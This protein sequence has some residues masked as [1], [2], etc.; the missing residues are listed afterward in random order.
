M[1]HTVQDTRRAE[2]LGA[3]YVLVGCGGLRGV[4]TS[5]DGTSAFL[6]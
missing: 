5:G 6:R 3:E 2:L 1:V 4:S